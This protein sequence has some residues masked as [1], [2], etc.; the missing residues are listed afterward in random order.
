MTIG[1]VRKTDGTEK[2]RSMPPVPA[3]CMNRR[4]QITG[5]ASYSLMVIQSTIAIARNSKAY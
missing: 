5:H 2:N 1:K 4:G 3:T